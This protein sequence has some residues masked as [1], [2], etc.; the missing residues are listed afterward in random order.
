MSR[1]LSLTQTVAQDAER[2][3]AIAPALAPERFRD[4]LAD[5]RELLLVG[6]SRRHERRVAVARGT[7]IDRV[8]ARRHPDRRKRLLDAAHVDRGRR[9]AI[10]RALVLEHLPGQAELDH[11]EHLEH[12]FPALLDVDSE[13]LELEVLVAVADTE[14]E[15]AARERVGEPDLAEQPRRCM[16]GRDDHRGSEPDPLGHRRGVRHHHQRRRA[17]AV[18]REVV[19]GEPRPPEPQRLRNF[20]YGG[21]RRRPARPTSRPRRAAA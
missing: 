5:R 21:S 3:G 9:L 13:A 19:L 15:P 16:Q 8:I 14:V 1:L 4:V 17:Q 2:H 12:P 6:E 11:V 7:L 10:V 20:G 18:V